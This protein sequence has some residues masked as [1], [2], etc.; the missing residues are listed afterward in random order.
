MNHC[1][2]CGEENTKFNIGENCTF[3]CWKCTA[4]KV[5]FV[6][7]LERETGMEITNNARYLMAIS[8]W[9]QQKRMRVENKLGL[10]F[11][12]WRK[13]KGWSRIATA[14]HLGISDNYLSKMESGVKP[15]IPKMLE[16]MDEKTHA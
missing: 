5:D 6:N 4:R 12:D 1:D 9:E 13:K 10:A 11:K 14:L 3:T 2:T 7:Q 16:F 8:E 15:L